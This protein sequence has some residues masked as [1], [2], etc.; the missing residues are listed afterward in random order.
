MKL[1]NRTITA[2]DIIALEPCYEDEQVHALVP[3]PTDLASLLDLNIPNEDIVWAV[4]RL[5][6]CKRERVWLGA[7]FVRETPLHD[8]RTVYDLLTDERSIAAIEVCEAYAL[9]Q[10]SDEELKAAE[11]AARAAAWDAGTA[12]WAAWAAWAAGAAGA[13]WA[14][15]RADARAAARAAAWDAW[16]AGAAWAAGAAAA[17]AHDTQVT[18]LRNSFK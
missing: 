14:T 17:A 7:Q 3:E 13:A 12:A 5:I 16:D 11:D 1:T 4:T 10:A 6:E 8:G 2:Q 15:A 18:I 9:G